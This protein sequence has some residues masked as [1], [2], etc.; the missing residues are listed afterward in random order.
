M[1]SPVVMRV[2]GL[3]GVDR[4]NFYTKAYTAVLFREAV[5][6]PNKQN[7]VVDMLHLTLTLYN[8]AYIEHTFTVCNS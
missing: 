2:I 1:V 4:S 3:N 5:E 6:P 7:T 8:A